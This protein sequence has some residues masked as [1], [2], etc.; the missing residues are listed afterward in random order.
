MTL[1]IFFTELPV[2]RGMAFTLLW[3]PSIIQGIESHYY[4]LIL[5]HGVYMCN[6]KFLCIKSFLKESKK[7]K[8]RVGR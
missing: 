1:K 5:I 3:G 6:K 2:T 4:V 7:I 8:S